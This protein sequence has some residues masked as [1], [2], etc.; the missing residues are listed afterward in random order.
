MIELELD[1]GFNVL[2]F[3]STKKNPKK[4]QN[5]DAQL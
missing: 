4:L 3:Q 5:N 2:F 1:D